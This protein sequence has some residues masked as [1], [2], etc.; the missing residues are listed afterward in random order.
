MA[1]PYDFNNCVLGCALE[2]PLCGT[3]SSLLI[4]YKYGVFQNNSKHGPWYLHH[5]RCSLNTGE[6]NGRSG[7]IYSVPCLLCL[8]APEHILDRNSLVSFL[9][10]ISLTHV[11]VSPR[12]IEPF[13][14]STHFCREELYADLSL[15]NPCL[16]SYTHSYNLTQNG[17]LGAHATLSAPHHSSMQRDLTHVTEALIHKPTSYLKPHSAQSKRLSA[18]AHRQSPHLTLNA[19]QYNLALTL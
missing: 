13:S 4:C 1:H 15:S 14:D 17:P 6:A 7:N 9:S 12:D 16:S 5:S 8:Q 18:K 2:L 11:Q 10:C 19:S 3:K